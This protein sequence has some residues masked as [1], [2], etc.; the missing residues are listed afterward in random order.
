MLQICDFMWDMDGAYHIMYIGTAAVR[1]Y[2]RK[3]DTGGAGHCPLARLARSVIG[4]VAVWVACVVT[5]AFPKGRV[6]VWHL[7]G[8]RKFGRVSLVVPQATG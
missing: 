5:H 1:I 3:Q 8:F 4:L 2:R 6:R 7:V